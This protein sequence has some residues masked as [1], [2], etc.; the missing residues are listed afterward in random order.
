MIHIDENG[1]KITETITVDEGDITKEFNFLKDC[2]YDRYLDD[3]D[4]A[5]LYGKE[6]CEAVAKICEYILTDADI[7]DILRKIDSLYC[8]DCMAGCQ[9]YYSLEDPELIQEA[10]HEWVEDIFNVEDL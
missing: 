3:D 10:I 9:V 5:E 8:D 6:L 1:L 2:W 4:S 7:L